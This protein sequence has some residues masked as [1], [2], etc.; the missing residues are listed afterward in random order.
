MTAL[1]IAPADVAARPFYVLVYPKPGRPDASVRQIAHSHD[2]CVTL[3]SLFRPFKARPDR[4]YRV[5]PALGTTRDVTLAVIG[6]AEGV[7]VAAH[8]G[9]DLRERHRAGLRRRN[10]SGASHVGR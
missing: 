9:P 10:L 4:V 5:V 8:E 1:G 6:E 3:A 7:E 2:E